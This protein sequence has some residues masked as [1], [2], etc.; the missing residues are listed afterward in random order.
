MA[1]FAFLGSDYD[2]HLEKAY[3]TMSNGDIFQPYGPVAILLSLANLKALPSMAD[4]RPLIQLVARMIDADVLNKVAHEHLKG[5]R[6]LIG[7]TQLDAQ[8]LVIWNMGAIAVSGHPEAL[9]LFRQHRVEGD[10]A[11]PANAGT[12]R[13]AIREATA[14]DHA[15]KVGQLGTARLQ[16]GHVHV[17]GFKPG[18]REGV[19]HLDVRVDALLTQYRHFGACQHQRRAGQI[20]Y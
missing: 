15:L 11:R 17:K 12:K 5:R 14:R 20:N 13:V 18:L 19:G 2:E 8:R 6:L 9:E 7:T 10:G 16:V 1:P 3:T 4:S